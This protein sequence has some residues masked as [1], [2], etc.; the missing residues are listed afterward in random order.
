MEFIAEVKTQSPFGFKSNRSWDYLFE[1]A[2]KIGD[3]I[4]I[5]TDPKW[6]GSFDLIK[7][8]RKLTNK[9]ILA[10]GIHSSN[11]DIVK[12]IDCGADFV[13][14]VGRNPNFLP[15]KVIIEP[16]SLAELELLKNYP[17]IIWNQRDLYY[18]SDKYTN[19]IMGK[20]E[21]F[22]NARNIYKGWLC[23]ASL[24]NN[25]FDINPDADAILVG[26]YLEN[27]KND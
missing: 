20:I 9:P 4:S 15:N 8:A 11:E 16:N 17:R 13:L 23:Q 21:Q 19:D 26:T 5:H 10:K 6:D 24:I 3:I 7:K 1:L 22:G 12:A 18:K 14:V 27:F 2:N 25:K